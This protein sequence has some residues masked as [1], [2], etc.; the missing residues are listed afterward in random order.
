VVK[1]ETEIQEVD[2]MRDVC[3]RTCILVV[4]AAGSL[5]FPAGPRV[6]AAP[7]S[8]GAEGI[9]SSVGT[10]SVV[11]ATES[12]NHIRVTTTSETHVVSRQPAR[13]ED[14]VAGEF[15]GVT[16]KK[17]AEGMLTAVAIN[18][19][20][21]PLRGQIR[22]G[23][24]PMETGDIMTNA[25]IAQ[26]VTRVSGHMLYLAYKNGTAMINVSPMAVVRRM[27]LITLGKLKTGMHVTTHGIQ[28]PDGSIAADFIIVDIFAR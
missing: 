28:N 25:V 2:I 19:F 17:E 21:A 8:A 6:D 5:A 10:A 14:V 24:W 1:G 4:L 9:I 13:L 18:I 11:I 7:A 3:L 12:G 15:V 16:A 23:Q 20:P 27:T 26:D 22:E